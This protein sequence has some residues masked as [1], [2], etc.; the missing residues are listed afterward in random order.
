MATWRQ[1]EVIYG[2]EQPYNIAFEMRYQ[3]PKE[4]KKKKKKNAHDHSD[5][6]K[7]SQA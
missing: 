2:N 5:T 7:E 6:S 1:E 4:D 3:P